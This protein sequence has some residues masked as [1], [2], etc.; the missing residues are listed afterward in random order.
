MPD[1]P[2]PTYSPPRPPPPYEE[3]NKNTPKEGNT[4]KI[5]PPPF[6]PLSGTSSSPMN[7]DASTLHTIP[8]NGPP[9]TIV[10]VQEVKEA[11]SF[12]PY[13]AFCP[14]CSQNVTTK[15][16]FVSGSLTWICFLF[17]L[18]F[19]FPLAFVP[20]C[21]DSCKDVQHYCPK[22]ASLLSIKKRFL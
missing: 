12:S 7:V 4:Y 21:L 2:P 19:F 18:F 8:I 16:T 11:P 14:K 1:S 15:Q 5:S 10:I 9:R 22:C 20:F 3:Q 17:V 6:V 13:M